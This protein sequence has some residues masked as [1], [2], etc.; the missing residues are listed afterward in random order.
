MSGNNESGFG[1]PVS[2]VEVGEGES[3]E[4]KPAFDRTPQKVLANLANQP[5]KQA[6]KAIEY[7]DAS[8]E[9]QRK[10]LRACSPKALSLI[11]ENGPEYLQATVA[12]AE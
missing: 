11:A 9:R 7:I 10:L 4:P 5:F 2:E 6:A 12:A 1:T 8:R 3:G